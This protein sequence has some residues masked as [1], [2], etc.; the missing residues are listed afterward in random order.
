MS[1]FN[2]ILL[3]FRAFHRHSKSII[4]S[5]M[6]AVA[7]GCAGCE[8][9]PYRRAFWCQRNAPNWQCGIVKSTME[10]FDLFASNTFSYFPHSRFPFFLYIGDLFGFGTRFEFYFICS[11]RVEWNGEV[12]K[13]STLPF[14]PLLALFEFHKIRVEKAEQITARVTRTMRKTEWFTRAARFG[15]I[16]FELCISNECRMDGCVRSCGRQWL[17]FRV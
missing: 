9:K 5:R 11:V 1:P 14:W 4:Y 2:L 6:N 15:T 13:D 16:I 8:Q 12:V 10:T 7:Y 17:E 3:S